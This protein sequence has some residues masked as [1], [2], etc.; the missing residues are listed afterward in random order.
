MLTARWKPRLIPKRTYQGSRRTQ[1]IE[2][3]RVTG[4]TSTS[5]TVEDASYHPIKG[6][7]QNTLPSGYRDTEAYK[8]YS[9]TKMYPAIEGT[10]NLA[11][12]IT[13]VRQDGSTLLTEVVKVEDWHYN[14]QGHY[15]AYVVKVNER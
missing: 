11:D 4:I 10:D 5:F 1:T 12:Q 2:R 14:V 6:F 13:L 15:L 8:I 3:G 7:E 9:T